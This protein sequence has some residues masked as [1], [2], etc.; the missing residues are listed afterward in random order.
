MLFGHLT[1][2]LIWFI[3]ICQVTLSACYICSCKRFYV[4]TKQKSKQ[5]YLWVVT[6]KNSCP[7]GCSVSAIPNY[8]IYYSCAQDNR[9]L[10]TWYLRNIQHKCLCNSWYVMEA[11]RT[12]QK[13]HCLRKH[14]KYVYTPFQFRERER[15]CCHYINRS[16]SD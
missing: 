2:P 12:E 8:Q 5:I 9:Y 6:T 16:N 14:L 4:C 15:V 10:C 7:I 3:F 13:L 11:S 1:C